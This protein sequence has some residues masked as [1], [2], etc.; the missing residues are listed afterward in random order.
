MFDGDNN[1]NLLL[2]KRAEHEALQA[3][4]MDCVPTV[5]CAG[6]ETHPG[7]C[8]A[9]FACREDTQPAILALGDPGEL[10][11]EGDHWEERTVVEPAL[12]LG[13]SEPDDD[14]YYVLG[15]EG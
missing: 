3:E 8:R 9:E 12:F 4:F 2:A 13:P 7:G 1:E 10:E 15:G 6:C 14:P 11:C 5:V